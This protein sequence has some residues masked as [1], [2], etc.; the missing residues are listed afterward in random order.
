[1]NQE[2]DASGVQSKNIEIFF[3]TVLTVNGSFVSGHVTTMK[4]LTCPKSSVKTKIFTQ[5]F[6]NRLR[7]NL[8]PCLPSF[9]GKNYI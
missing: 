9:I 6:N 4:L 3:H 2:T 5:T 1:M 8:R 7:V